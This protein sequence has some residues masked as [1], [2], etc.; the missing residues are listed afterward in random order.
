MDLVGVGECS[1]ELAFFFFLLPLKSVF[2]TLHFTGKAVN[3]SPCKHR[4]V[5]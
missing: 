5:R 4:I 1:F 2:L 3:V